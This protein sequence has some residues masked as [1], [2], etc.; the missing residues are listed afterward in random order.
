MTNLQDTLNT[1]DPKKRVLFS[2]LIKRTKPED[3]M[4]LEQGLQK[5]LGLSIQQFQDAYSQTMEI[6]GARRYHVPK[7]YPDINSW[8]KTTGQQYVRVFGN[9][10]ALMREDEAFYATTNTIGA[11]IGHQVPPAIYYL[12]SAI[13]TALSQTDLR[14]DHLVTLKRA[15]VCGVF[16]LPKGLLTN[17]DGDWLECIAFAYTKPDDTTVL[18]FGD[19]LEKRALHCIRY[20]KPI[21]HLMATTQ[22]AVYGTNILFDSEDNPRL[23]IQEIEDGFA[24]LT[25]GEL[26]VISSQDAERQF[27]QQFRDLSLQCLLIMQI[28]P[29]LISDEEELKGAKRT[30]GQGFGAQISS[31]PILSPNW[32][33]RDYQIKKESSSEQ[34][35]KEA[36]QKKRAS[37]RTHWRKG[38]FAN[39]P[40]GPMNVHP[41]PSRMRWR[42]PKIINAHA[43]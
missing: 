32:I 31:K 1:F 16:V 17:P 29:D 41:R 23:E 9:H 20:Q 3:M 14:V 43:D 8:L 33:G 13:G 15:V 39:V 4:M 6:L 38:H 42:E 28:R 22:S 24:A 36:Q 12:S 30:K 7:S 35:V 27:I 18:N 34:V 19:R 2:K 21:I 26:S 25:G 10:Y 11:I 37:P 5:G 40:Y